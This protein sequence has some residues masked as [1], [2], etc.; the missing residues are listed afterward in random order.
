MLLLLLCTRRVDIFAV[1]M[2]RL[3]ANLEGG[4]DGTSS[5][6][7]GETTAAVSPLSSSSGRKV[8]FFA[9]VF[10]IIEA[11]DAFDFDRYEIF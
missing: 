10:C 11:S 2:L 7:A 9:F 6:A 4:G 8:I 1:S 3:R 5:R